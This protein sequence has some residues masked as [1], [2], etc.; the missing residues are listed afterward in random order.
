MCLQKKIVKKGEEKK[1][2]R[3]VLSFQFTM[4]IKIFTYLFLLIFGFSY[5]RNL[6]QKKWYLASSLLVEWVAIV[7][8]LNLYNFFIQNVYICITFCIEF[9]IYK[10]L[11]YR[12]KEANTD[13]SFFLIFLT[14]RRNTNRKSK[15]FFSSNRRKG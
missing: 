12:H 9:F 4:L 8:Q 10:I 14:G 5:S 1:E 2:V 6:K 7:Y 13:L 11:L 15:K 3:M